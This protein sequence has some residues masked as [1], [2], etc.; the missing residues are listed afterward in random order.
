MHIFLLFLR[1]NQLGCTSA[2][3][4]AKDLI[5]DVPLLD[6]DGTEKEREEKERKKAQHLIGFKPMTS[7][8][9]RVCST[10]VLQPL[11]RFNE[12]LL[13]LQPQ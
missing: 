4:H 6:R 11:P 2:R 9:Q 12:L 7:L 8:S 10:A 3:G 1:K 5:K 13:S